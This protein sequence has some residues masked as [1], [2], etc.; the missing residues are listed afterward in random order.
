[1]EGGPRRGFGDRYGVLVGIV[2][3]VAALVVAVVALWPAFVTTRV[4]Q[5]P[6]LRI[7][8]FTIGTRE[9]V[10]AE[11]YGFDRAGEIDK[12]GE[13]RTNVATASV[14]VRN[15]GEE[16][17]FLT[18][19]RLRLTGIWF[20]R[21]CGGGPGAAKI[22]YDFVL[23]GDADRRPTP[24]MLEKDVQFIVEGKSVDLFAF[25]AGQE[26]IGETGWSSIVAG[27]AELVQDNGDVLRTQPFVLMDDTLVN[28]IVTNAARAGNG[29]ASQQCIG[30]PLGMV[31]EALAAPGKKSP[32]I[33]E[34]HDRLV[35]LGF[36][37]GDTDPGTTPTPTTPTTTGTTSRPPGEEAANTW[38]AQ[39][40][41]LPAGTPA[42]EV[43]RQ[44][45]RIGSET[46]LAT[47]VLNS[48]DFV[49]LTPGYS[50]VYHAGGFPD[51][52]AAL[53]AC[54]THGRSDENAC[55][56]RY[57]SHFSQHATLICRFSD[58][59]AARG[60]TRR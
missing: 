4:L 42:T 53:D 59:P 20:P 27:T 49:S 36:R 1:V 6:D 34:L 15:S 48:S 9:D 60:C 11:D 28:G 30:P 2:L 17:A 22:A 24:V 25:S 44:R 58:G 50:V 5:N 47:S 33:Q 19:L 56:G 52:Y 14:A 8:G 35:A 10:L 31:K 37:P 46:G 39:L 23:P 12:I 21:G 29:F 16:P 13:H 43:E 55:V 32:A 45:T 57:L 40:A 18:R 51:G 3:S 54:R 7:V 26:W 38:I 41:S